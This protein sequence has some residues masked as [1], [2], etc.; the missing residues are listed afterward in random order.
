MAGT[1]DIVA[2]VLRAEEARCKAISTENWDALAEIAGDD[3]V[4]THSTGT[5]QTKAEWLEGIK[6]DRRDIEHDRLKVRVLTDDVALLSGGSTNHY[7]RPFT[8]DSHYGVVL[9][10][11]QVWVKRDGKW[12]IVAQHGVKDTSRDSLD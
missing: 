4:Y 8:G 12:M 6:K 7:D 1:D 9:D 2:E 3:F 5:T 10:I 11:L